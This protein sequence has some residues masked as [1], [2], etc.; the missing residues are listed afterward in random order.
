[1]T[2]S[3]QLRQGNELG[4]LSAEKFEIYKDKYRHLLEEIRVD[5]DELGAIGTIRRATDLSR[6]TGQCFSAAEYPQYFVG[7]LDAS[8]VLVHLN[9]KGIINPPARFSGHVQSLTE[10]VAAF[11]KFGNRM[12][13]ASSGRLHRSPFDHKQI[14]FLRPFDVIDFVEERGSGDR[15]INLE[16]VIDRKLQLELIP[17]ASPTFSSTG[18]SEQVLRPHY[19]RMMSVIAARDRKYVMFCGS[20]F[21][22]ILRKYIIASFEFVLPKVDGGSSRSK[23]RFSTLR[24]PYGGKVFEAGLAPSW[25]RQGINMRAYGQK[26]HSLSRE[27]NGDRR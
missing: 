19:E 20:V 15:Y 24:L 17:Y 22:P 6:N 10:Y 5:L 14:R 3:S 2:D 11:S 16:R 26:I 21:E 27:L 9:P 8:F 4:T 7:D 13:G 25:A 12:Y 23:S 18:L 1:V